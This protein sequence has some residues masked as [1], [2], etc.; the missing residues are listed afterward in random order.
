LVSR[1]DSPETCQVFFPYVRL[2][3]RGAIISPSHSRS[4]AGDGFELVLKE[5]VVDALERLAL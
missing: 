3:A 4:K 5:E 2:S 1:S